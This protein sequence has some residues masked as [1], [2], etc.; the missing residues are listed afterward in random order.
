ML[1]V[2]ALYVMICQPYLLMNVINFRFKE[3]QYQINQVVLITPHTKILVN[4][5][6]I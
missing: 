1:K 4:I 5:S 3:R 6:L 2:R